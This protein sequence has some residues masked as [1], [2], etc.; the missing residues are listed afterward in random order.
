MANTINTT[1]CIA[2]GGPAGIMA[3]YLLARAGVDVVVLEKHND[4]FRDFRGDTIH[5]STM[6]VMYQAGVLE[7][8]LKIP[9]QRI[10]NLQLHANDD[11]V[12]LADFTHLPVHASY[13][14][15]MPQW[16]FLNFIAGKA[17]QY[18]N[19][20]LLMGTTATGLLMQQNK[21]TGVTAHSPEGPIEI[22]ATLTIA[23][24][25]RGSTLKQAAGMPTIETGVPI[26]VLWFRLP[27]DNAETGHVLAYIR[28]NKIMIVIDRGD[29]YQCGYIIPKGKFADKQQQGLALFQKNIESVAPILTDKASTLQNWDSIKLLSV[30]INHL[31]KW[32]KNG[33]LFIGDAAH[34]MSPAFGVGVNI[35]VQDAV[36]TANILT[37]PLLNNKLAVSHL[38]QV[39]KRRMFPARFTQKVQSVL[40]NRVVRTDKPVGNIETILWFFKHFPIL[41]RLPGRFVGMG[42]RPES[43]SRNLLQ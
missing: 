12:E 31:P 16:D 27:K 2:G 24:D 21:V 35:A 34:A 3:G 37:Q 19:F 5:P 25:G 33:L 13:I 10:G 29:Y 8:F 17:K 23:A 32:Y 4:F 15:I 41:R 22:N 14:A 9:H 7:E 28:N 40:H 26:D 11:I 20:K 42:I 38:Q 43:I 1:C 18:K 36:A 6:E 30:Q 39:Q